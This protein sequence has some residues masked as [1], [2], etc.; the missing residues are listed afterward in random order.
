MST[1]NNSQT[2]LKSIITVGLAHGKTN[3]QLFTM[4]RNNGHNVT[5]QDIVNLRTKQEN[6]FQSSFDAIFL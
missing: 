4:A 3:Q 6:E 1:N 5:Y 2:S